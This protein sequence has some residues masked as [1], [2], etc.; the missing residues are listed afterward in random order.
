MD[1]TL[2]NQIESTIKEEKIN[3]KWV[4]GTQGD[5]LVINLA[6]KFSFDL[7]KLFIWSQE[8]TSDYYDYEGEEFD[9]EKIL[10]SLLDNFTQ[11]IYICVTNEDLFPWQLLQCDKG[12]CIRLLTN[13]PFFEYFIFDSSM[14]CVLFDTH[15]NSIIVFR[16]NIG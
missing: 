15:D 10:S 1:K 4:P 16:S 2:I 12:D 3:G 9:W 14:R 7:N 13:L 8:G 6:K 5:L 11:S